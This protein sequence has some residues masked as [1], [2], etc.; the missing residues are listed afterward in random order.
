MGEGYVQHAD[1]Q[2]AG[3]QAERCQDKKGK[4][5]SVKGAK[6]PKK[7]ELVDILHVANSSGVHED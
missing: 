2:S 4:K 5:S 1:H 6:D 7:C 3:F